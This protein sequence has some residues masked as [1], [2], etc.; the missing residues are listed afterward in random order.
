M[1]IEQLSTILGIPQDQIF[2][3]VT[4]IVCF[5]L[6]G[7]IN[8]IS[9]PRFKLLYCL[10]LGIAVQGMLYGKRIV[11]V[12]ISDFVILAILKVVPRKRV[13]LIVNITTFSFLLYL[14]L[15]RLYSNYGGWAIDISLL[16]M[17]ITPRHAAYG[18]NYQD[19][20]IDSNEVESE[21]VKEKDK[22]SV[23]DIDLLAFFSYIHALPTSLIGPFNEYN[24]YM[25]F[26]YQKNDYSDIYISFNVISTKFFLFIVT[27]IIYVISIPYSNVKNFVSKINDISFAASIGNSSLLDYIYPIIIYLS[28]R[29]FFKMKYFTGF[30][31][32]EMC[33]DVSGISYNQKYRLTSEN[34]SKVQHAR[35]LEVE[36]TWSIKK[37]FKV[38]NISIHNWL[39]NYCFKRVVSTVGKNGAVILTFTYSCV[40]HGFY[41]SYYVVFSYFILVQFAQESIYKF[42][43]YINNSIKNRFLWSLIFVAFNGVYYLSF[44]ISYSYV[45]VC[46]E[47]LRWRELIEFTVEYYC[48]PI[49]AILIIF[50]LAGFSELFFILKKGKGKKLENEN[51][52]N[53]VKL[54][55]RL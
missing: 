17:N 11:E 51:S 4:F 13:G 46:L 54:S 30:Y 49:I 36:A 29:Y 16:Y 21:T 12:I 19:G 40:W 25:N 24:D 35:P 20:E 5:V 7:L 18:F 55:K 14:H 53:K 37:F 47:L 42:Q 3:L 8:F 9:N 45:G 23:K 10:V 2:F 26:I 43:E 38:W 6:S 50:V 27:T 32:S 34:N 52:S 33:C 39:K 22:Y 48:F 31:L 15:E 28:I 41:L 1:A 44:W